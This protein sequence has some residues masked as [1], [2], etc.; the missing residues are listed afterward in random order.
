[1]RQIKF[2]AWDENAKRM[3]YNPTR[4]GFMDGTIGINHFFDA[5]QTPM[6]CTGLKDKHGKEIFEGDLVK[7]HYSAGDYTGMIALVEWCGDCCYGYRLQFV[8]LGN[9]ESLGNYARCGLE[10]IGNAYENP[11]LLDSSLKDTEQVRP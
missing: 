6:Q 1:M 11:E 7:L 8:G 4:D 5:D 9:N 2:R 10:V 3:D